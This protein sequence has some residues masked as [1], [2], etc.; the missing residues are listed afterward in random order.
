MKNRI[1]IFP[2]LVV[3]IAF[4]FFF[5]NWA[6]GDMDTTSPLYQGTV[7]FIKKKTFSPVD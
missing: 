7:K 2:N 5:L 4:G 1:S 3:I 6:A